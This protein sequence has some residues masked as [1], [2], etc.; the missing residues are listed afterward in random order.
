M[1]DLGTDLQDDDT[2]RSTMDLIY[3]CHALDMS[4]SHDKW[5]FCIRS[6][7]STHGLMTAYSIFIIVSTRW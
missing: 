1:G 6:F 7:F 2:V 5:C 3:H 4:M